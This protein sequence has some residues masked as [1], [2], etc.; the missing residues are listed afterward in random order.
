M[1]V[2]ILPFSKSYQSVHILPYNLISRC[3]NNKEGPENKLGLKSSTQ[4][5]KTENAF[6]I[7]D[8][9]LCSFSKLL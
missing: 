2:H 1:L 4:N 6:Q 3:F 9:D 5:N 8:R 7:L